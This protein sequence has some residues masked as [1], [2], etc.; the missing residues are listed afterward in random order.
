MSTSAT[1]F[2][3]TTSTTAAAAQATPRQPSTV[4]KYALPNALVLQGVV[5]STGKM[6]RTAKVSVE[7]KVTDHK[8]LKVFRQHKKYLIHDPDSTCV[9]GDQV[10]I[11]NCKPVSK[12]KR[13]E[14]LQVVKGARERTESHGQAIEELQKTA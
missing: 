12:R 5:T 8:T 13:F 6:E 14:L 1:T 7:R 4:S 2:E 11:R 10:S 9:V 3:P